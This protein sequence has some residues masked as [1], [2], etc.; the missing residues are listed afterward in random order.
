MA[1]ITVAMGAFVHEFEVDDDA[2]A[3][4]FAQQATQKFARGQGKWIGGGPIDVADGMSTHMLRI[5]PTALIRIDL[6]GDLTG[7]VVRDMQALESGVS[8]D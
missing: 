6:D 4:R 8:L 3:V 5:P 1:K 7:D 2:Q